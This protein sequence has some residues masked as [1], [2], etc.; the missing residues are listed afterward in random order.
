MMDK[1]VRKNIAILATLDTKSKEVAYMKELF[2]T[3]G[4]STTMI[5]VG[6]L[7]PPGMQPDISSEEIARWGGGNLPGLVQTGEKDRIMEGMGKGAMQVLSHLY[8]EGRIDGVIGIG[9]NQGSSIAS[10]AM[11]ALPFGFPKYLVST[12]ASGNIRPYVGCK[13]IGVV[14][15]VGDFLGGPNPVTRSVLANAVAAVI[16]MVEHGSR[17]NLEAGDRTIGVTALGN[18]E[19]AVNQAVNL[20]HENGF[21]VIP[22]HASGAGGSAMEELVEE[23]II[24]GVLD[25][26]PHELTEEVVGVGAYL[27]VKPGRLKA[28]GAKGIPQVVSTGGM[29]YLCFGPKESIPLRF[30]NRKIYM[31]NPYN[32]NVRASR[33]EM[34]QVG[35]T[36]AERLNGARGPTAVMIPLRGWSIYGAKGGPLFDA[37]GDKVFLEALKNHLRTGILLEEVD[38]HINDLFF[39]D[40]CVKQLVEFM[41][42][43]RN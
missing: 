17:V 11:K 38:A 13:D 6:S 33:N 8:R 36:M 15:S 7:G 25:L 24:H 12:V 26:T 39:V 21:Q 30:R 19:P 35:K 32:A 9:G 34:A 22:F 1:I 27:P 18:T 4:Y 2:E 28:A 41:N 20:L 10:M 14:F 37:V 42:G 3:Q 43:G 29:E 40:R 5:D 31:H 16:G 23:G